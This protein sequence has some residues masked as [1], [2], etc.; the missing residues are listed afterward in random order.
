VDFAQIPKA[1]GNS[2]YLLLFVV[3][4]SNWV[5]V[6]PTRMEKTLG[7]VQALLKDNIPIY[8]IPDSIQS[9]NGPAFASEIMKRMSETLGICWE[10]CAS[11]WR[12]QSTGKTKIKNHTLKRH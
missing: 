8:G 1:F 10:L 7:V 5:K 9:D 11:A 2:K 3:T 4:L 12:P 6:Y